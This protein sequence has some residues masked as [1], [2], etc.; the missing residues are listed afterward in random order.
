MNIK[1]RLENLRNMMK[2]KF[3]SALLVTQDQNR[4]YLSG[5]TGSTGWLLITAK[6]AAIIT[7]FRYWEQAGR[8]SSHFRLVKVNNFAEN[9]MIKSLLGLLKE[10]RVKTLWF[11]ADALSY[12]QYLALKENLKEI[13][14]ESKSGFVEELRAVKG[15]GELELIKK[16]STIADDAFLEIQKLIKPGITEKELAIELLYKMRKR[17]AEKEAFD[18]IV[19]SGPNSALPHAKNT[20][21]RI[22]EGDFVIF[23]FGAVYNGYHSDMTRTVIIG[24]PDKKHREIYS[25]VL[26]SQRKAL[27][28]I[29]AGMTC[30][31]A[32]LLA[33]QVIEEGGFCEYFGH[34]LGHGIGLAVHEEPR[35]RKGNEALLKA[36]MVVS[37]EPGIY[38]PGFGGVRIEDLVEVTEKGCR[39]LTRAPKEEL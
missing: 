17:G 28:T 25:L 8:E 18:I 3:I 39:V 15:K 30:G 12:S 33:R 19:A 10:L 5:F 31:G 1:E 34:G 4:R 35:L 27:K 36:G 26:E 29:K 24:K 6:E 22:K 7:D 2:R 20:D 9:G 16:A 14:L 13:K 37:V 32:D 21:R 23:D 38:I 11:E